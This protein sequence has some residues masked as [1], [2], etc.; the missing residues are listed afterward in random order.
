MACGNNRLLLHAYF[1]G[2]LDLVRSLEIEEHLKS[3][4][5]CAEELQKQRSLRSALRS[6]GLYQSAPS[7]LRQRMAESARAESGEPMDVRHR[8]EMKAASMPARPRRWTTWE[9][10]GVAAGVALVLFVGVKAL[11]DWQGARHSDLLAEEMVASHIRSLQPGHLYDVESTD[12]HTVKPWFA[13][14]VDFSPPVRDLAAQGY[15]LAGGRLDYIGSRAVAALVY[16]RRKHIINV[17]VWPESSGDRTLAQG[18]QE[19]E[20]HDGY[21]LIEWRQGDM[22]LCAVSDLG[23][24][25]LKQFVQLLQQQ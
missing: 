21:N 9:W 18:S 23:T 24:D 13:G 14:K 15:P 11:S 5:A 16:Q 1:D 4:T 6:G 7:S 20:S 8:A 10:I 3:C 2:E 25:D 17:F 12:Q 22:H 19:R